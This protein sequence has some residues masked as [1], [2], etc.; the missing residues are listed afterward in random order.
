MV[1]LVLLYELVPWWMWLPPLLLVV[2]PLLAHHGR[3]KDKPILR[4]ATVTPRFRKL[5]AD[6]VLRAYYAAGLGHP[7]KPGLQVTFGST[8]ARDGEGSAVDVDLPYGKGLKDAINAKDSL[9]SGLDVQVSQ[10]FLHRDPTSNRRHR[11]WVAD[12]D[13]LAVPVGRTPLLA[14]RQTDIWKPAP[15][16]LDERGQLVTVPLMWNSV[17]VSALP[18]AGKTFSARLLALFAALDPYTM[19]D[20]FDFKG[21]PDWRKF[22]LV[23]DSCAFGLTPTKDGLPGEIFRATLERIKEDVQDRYRRL[24]ELAD[25]HPELCPEGKLTTEARA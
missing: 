7:E 11:L 18:R 14:C 3:P 21:S 10:V 20:V 6:I 2:V 5:N 16:G 23:A 4:P 17:L 25:R 12:R 13:P 8:M 15:F 1:G 9:A 19:L 24:S 22:A